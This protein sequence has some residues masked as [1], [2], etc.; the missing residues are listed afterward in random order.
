MKCFSRL[1]ITPVVFAFFYLPFPQTTD[2]HYLD[3][4]SGSI[5][6]QVVIA[7]AVGGLFAVKLFWYRIKAFLKS[8]FSRGRE[9]ERSEK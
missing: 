1:T 4:G 9:I 3:P 7:V 2:G 6:I 8:L 5:I